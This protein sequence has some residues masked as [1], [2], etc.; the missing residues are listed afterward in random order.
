MVAVIG[1][2][3]SLEALTVASGGLVRLRRRRDAKRG[4][5]VLWLVILLLVV[6]A[7]AVLV[8][9][10][11]P[12]PGVTQATEA[13]AVVPAAGLGAVALFLTWYLAMRIVFEAPAH[14]QL[15][16]ARAA[17]AAGDPERAI[18]GWMAALP[19]LR[20]GHN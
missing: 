13:A 2:V 18:E 14:A 17:R 7:A 5:W 16:V 1:Y 12:G 4:G 11:L 6:A 8:R 15:K 20:R 19:A 10:F 9:A 3:L